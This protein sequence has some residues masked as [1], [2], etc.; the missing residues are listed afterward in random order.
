VEMDPTWP[1]EKPVAQG[2]IF[3]I[4]CQDGG[5]SSLPHFLNSS[6]P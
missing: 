2:K 5:T 6:L 1:D 3:H 4:Y